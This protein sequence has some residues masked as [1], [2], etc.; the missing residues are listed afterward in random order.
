MKHIK[1][2]FQKFLIDGLSGMALG[3]FCT[4]ICGTILAQIASLIGD[5]AAGRLVGTIATAAKV[6]TGAGIGAGVAVKFKETSPLVVVSAAAAGTIGAYASPILAGTFLS[7]SAVNL[8]GPGEPLGA[9]LA[10]FAAI[11]I[12]HLVAGKTKLDII[13]TPFTMLAVGSV[14][15]LLLGPPI[16]GFM[17]YLGEIIMWATNEQ[18]LVMGIVVSVLMG[19]ALTLPIS[20]AALGIS[21]KLGGIAAGASVIGCCAQMVGFAVSSYRENKVGGLVAQGVGTSMLQMPNIVQHPL[22]WLPPTITSA[23][24]GPIGTMVFKLECDMTGAGMGTSGLVGPIM[25]FKTMTENG[26][27][28]WAV[29]GIIVLL[30]FVAP[31]II[32]LG[33]SE[34]MRKMK[35][36]KPG[37]MK[38]S[39]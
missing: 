35:L 8:A 20:S 11:E 29:L 28:I 22:I 10:A 33:I 18:P 32:S 12:G 31:A 30:E 15:G 4:L 37:E 9:F 26:G 38:I 23:I 16:S 2:F 17:T 36:I 5:N 27:N 6:L 21:L 13:L 7:G 34:L 1:A 3:L 25:T 19:L 14:V 39:A 24:L